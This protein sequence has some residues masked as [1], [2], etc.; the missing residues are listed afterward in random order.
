MPID[1]IVLTFFAILWVV[2]APFYLKF[3]ANMTEKSVRVD[4][5]L[6]FYTKKRILRTTVTLLTCAI[7]GV[8][9]VNGLIISIKLRSGIFT[10]N[11]KEIFILALYFVT[12]LIIAFGAGAY[13]SSILVEQFT[14][15]DLKKHNAFK[16]LGLANEFFHG[17]VSHVSFFS[18]GLILLLLIAFL[19]KY[20]QAKNIETIH[21]YFYSFYGVLIGVIMF[22]SQFVNGTWKH[23][24]PFV[25]A[26]NFVHWVF[27][28]K[29]ISGFS[30][31]YSLPYN[32]FYLCLNSIFLI[33]LLGLLFH[34]R[35]NGTHYRY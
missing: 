26:T 3:R 17:P 35:K 7:A 16:T 10:F 21:L 12:C 23:Q 25:I 31:F 19:E 15:N 5:K 1:L 8:L 13:I 14:L 22:V 33:G 2:I 27:V 18:G 6:S 9:F 24:I 11:N 34:H 4:R 32:L 28:A 20:N 30:D 29:N